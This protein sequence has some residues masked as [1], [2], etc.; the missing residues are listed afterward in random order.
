MSIRAL[1]WAFKIIAG[2]P[3]S[4]SERLV[5]LAIC[6]RHN[7]RTGRCDPSISTL[8][9]MS[10]LSR[11]RATTALSSLDR[12][13]VIETVHRNTSR[14]RISNQYI[15]PGRASASLP[16]MT[17]G[18]LGGGRASASPNKEEITYKGR[19]G[20]EVVDFHIEGMKFRGSVNG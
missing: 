20:G 14:G 9:V 6:H 16:P 12:R 7:E 15:V 10:G 18:A 17:G 13:G 8:A 3:L 4:A 11:R 5:L 2:S 1:N 19:E